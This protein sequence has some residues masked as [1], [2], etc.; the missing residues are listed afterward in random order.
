MERS[1]AARQLQCLC[2][3]WFPTRE[4]PLAAIKVLN[5]TSGFDPTDLIIRPL[6]A[7]MKSSRTILIR[8]WTPLLMTFIAALHYASVPASAQFRGPDKELSKAGNSVRSRSKNR[9]PMR[10]DP[11]HW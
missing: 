3:D 9:S 6:S 5:K 4:L 1:G 10:P 11:L 7:H 2:F 8:R